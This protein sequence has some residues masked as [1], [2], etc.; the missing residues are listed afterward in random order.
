MHTILLIEDDQEINQMVAD[1]L[2]NEGFEVKVAF[3]GEEAMTLFNEGEIDLVLLDLM[4]PKLDGMSVMKRMRQQAMTPIV[5]ISAK[6]T[7][8]DKALGLGFGADDYLTKPFSLVE[9][10]ARIK[11]NIRRATQYIVVNQEKQEDVIRYKD[12]EIN[13]NQFSVAKKGKEIKLTMKEYEILRL[14]AT[15]INQVFTKS[16]IYNAVWK[17]NYYG[18]ENLINVHIRRLRE[19]IEDNP[20]EPEYIETLWGIG[21]KMGDN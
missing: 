18:D 14:L 4:L 5:I 2:R 19:K 20:S 6:D 9:L 1:Y 15:H 13:L 12:L 3:D 16:Q 11:A 10:S 21:Y 7:D 8:T 17:E